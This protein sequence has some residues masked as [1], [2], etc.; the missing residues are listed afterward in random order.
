[1]PIL[2]SA[3][4][5]YHVFDLALQLQKHALLDGLVTAYPKSKL[6][7]YAGLQSAV[8]SMPRFAVARKATLTLD[9]LIG[10]G[11]TSPLHEL[12]Y[13][14]FS[15]AVDAA[16][17]DRNTNVVYGLSGY[18][19]ELLQSPVRRARTTVVDHGSLHIET[20]E[21]ILRRECERFGFAPFGNWQYDWLVR[22]MDEEFELASHVVCCS[23]LAR[24]TM[25]EQG[26]DASKVV[27]HRLGV[28]LGQFRRLPR[29]ERPAGSRLRLLFVGAMTPLKG[30]H[31]LLSAFSALPPDTE[32][33]LV[34]ALPTDP[35]L[36][37]M[38]DDCLRDTGRLRVIGPVP[39]GELNEIY[40]QC[41]VFVLPSLSD[42]WGMVVS[43]A[44]ACGLP[45]V[46]SSM[47]GAKELIT[48]G[49][50]GFVVN[51]G[52]LDDLAD[53]LRQAL[54]LC[55]EGHWRNGLEGSASNIQ[56]NSWDDYGNGWAQWLRQ[57]GG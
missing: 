36:Q 6:G 35:V 53:K 12:V 50:N 54:E 25:I 40:N 55:R 14:R 20:E 42:G 32:L 44:L 13:R 10:A 24:E 57:I 31:Y 37:A 2:L 11:K 23:E 3:L 39:Q 18:M 52:D 46:V 22:R 45:A 51:S 19:K 16:H 26:V 34:G 48:P 4:T 1:M 8:I 15:H 7:R 21:R 41:D 29:H 5:R 17:R 27:V 30:L 49:E 56:A 43:Q 33:W 47:T 28:D 38:I 9:R